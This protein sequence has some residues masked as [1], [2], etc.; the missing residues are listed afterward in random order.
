MINTPLL[1]IELSAKRTSW[2]LADKHA[3]EY[4]KR[5]DG[6]RQR[7][8][9]RDDH[10]CRFCGFR[11]VPAKGE[12]G[13]PGPSWQEVHHL[14]DDHSNNEMSNLVTACCLCHQC[15]HLGLAG[16]K[17]GG[18]LIYM[19]EISQAQLNHLSRAIFI[20]IASNGEYAQPARSLLASLESRAMFVDE[21]YAPGASNP[22]FLGQTFLSMTPE[23]YAKRGEAIRDIR[24]LP[25][26]TR[27]E[28]QIAFWIKH[29]FRNN[30]PENWEQFLEKP[31]E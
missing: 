24:L 23:Q 8:L 15:F 16:M 4:D 31:T 14:D 27:F 9:E 7:V 1:P 21:Y 20:A 2:R 11:S 19:P 18:V 26:P 5:F 10:T 25:F 6:I 3:T 29:T 22:S 17:N 12:K 30:L 13:Q 28:D